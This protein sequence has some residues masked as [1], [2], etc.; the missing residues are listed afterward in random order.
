MFLVLKWSVFRTP[1][2][3]INVTFKMSKRN[4]KKKNCYLKIHFSRSGVPKQR[5]SVIPNAV[6]CDMFH[7]KYDNDDA[8]TDAIKRFKI[9]DNNLFGF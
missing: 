6:D 1:L 9:T 4:F 5:V 7:P 8:D 3:Y 2:Y